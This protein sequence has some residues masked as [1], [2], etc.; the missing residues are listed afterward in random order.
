MATLRLLTN[1]QLVGKLAINFIF[2]IIE[3][4]SLSLTVEMLQAE[5]RQSQRFSKGVGHFEHRF[6]TE[7]SVAHQPLLV[8]G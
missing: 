5:I 2:V 4:L 7:V 3:L 1:T 8:S 6:Q